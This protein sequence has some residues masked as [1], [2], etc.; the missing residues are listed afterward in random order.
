MRP[1]AIDLYTGLHGWGEGFVAE[2]FLV[3]GVDIVDMCK[4]L[5]Q[6]RHEGIELLLADVLTLHGAQFKDAAVIVASPPC[7]EP[8][9]RAMPW[10]RA[11]AL[12]AAGPPYKFIA[13]FEACFRI[14]RE[15][16]EAAGRH[17]PL[18]VENVKGAQPWVGRA[19][20]HF[21]SYY[22]WGDIPA[23]MP[24]PRSRAMKENPDGT[25]HPPGSW[26]AIAN[27][28][29]RGAKSEGQD[30]SRF[31]KTGEVSPHWRM[32]AIK[33]EGGSWFNVAHNMASG[34]GQ[35]PDGRKQK[36][37]GRIWFDTGIAK[38]G[39]NSIKRKLASAQI[40][41]IPFPLALHIARCFKPQEAK[42]SA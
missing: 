25:G 10:K 24:I 18:I 13:L 21:G 28:K 8:S 27:S 12:N 35:N 31:A 33:N 14:Q 37:S 42:K 5:G 23:L 19:Q 9:Y 20:W 1:L 3:V 38:H 30:W 39:S 4:E 36:G 41:K 16:S 26:F 7:T 29:N 32:E 22:L 40:A 11:K 34:C 2:G 17:I 6:P 15:A